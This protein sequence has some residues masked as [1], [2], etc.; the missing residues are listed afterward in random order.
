MLIPF[1]FFAK[2]PSL[3][4]WF[5]ASESHHFW[6]FS[7][8]VGDNQLENWIS[9]F[10]FSMSIK[11]PFTPRIGLQTD[12]QEA[13]HISGLKSVGFPTI[14]VDLHA[15]LWYVSWD[16]MGFPNISEANIWGFLGRHAFQGT[17]CD[18]RTWWSLWPGTQFVTWGVWNLKMPWENVWFSG[19]CLISI[20]IC[21]CIPYV[22]VCVHVY[23]F[24]FDI[25]Y[26]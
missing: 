25:I 2:Q 15:F 20:Y 4:V 11:T 18:I 21:I 22:F 1:T 26:M 6:G 13:S 16:P 5:V 9:G 10:S 14:L 3:G 17:S 7:I 19:H 23:I 8:Y 24:T 12:L